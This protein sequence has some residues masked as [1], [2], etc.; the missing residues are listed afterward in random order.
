MGENWMKLIIFDQISIGNLE[1]C[2]VSLLQQD[3]A[4]E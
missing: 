4:A 3:R 1:L 2:V